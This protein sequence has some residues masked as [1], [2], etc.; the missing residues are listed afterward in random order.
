MEIDMRGFTRFYDMPGNIS[1]E[2]GLVHIDM[3]DKR[4]SADAEAQTSPYIF[5]ERVSLSYQGFERLYEM[6]GQVVNTLE[7][8]GV[9]TRT[10][11][12]KKPEAAEASD[13]K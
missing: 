7:K 1:I 3:F 10:K 4:P 11:K 12:A 13:T 5:S 8:K 2:H 6:I 9:L